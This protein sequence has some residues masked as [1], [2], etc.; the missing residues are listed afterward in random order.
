MQSSLVVRVLGAAL[1]AGAAGV[2]RA[3]VQAAPQITIDRISVAELRGLS[4]GTVLVVDVRGESSYALGHIPGAINVPYH[5]VA[6]R[7]S[8]IARLAARRL[9]VTYC[10][11]STDHL[12]VEAAL[13][14]SAAALP[15]VRALAGGFPAWVQA[16]GA[17]ERDTRIVIPNAQRSAAASSAKN[18]RNPSSS[19][20]TTSARIRK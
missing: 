10:S 15:K 20:T 13:L 2:P 11:C 9:V 14:L 7:A 18:L 4:S 16:G 6:A 12:S 1:L 17:T 3:A 19:S 5:A 8:D